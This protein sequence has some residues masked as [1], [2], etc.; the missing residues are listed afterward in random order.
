MSA[1]KKYVPAVPFSIKQ[2]P[3]LSEQWIKELIISNPSILGLEGELQ[4]SAVEKVQAS[5]GRLDLQLGDIDSDRRYEVEIQLGAT[6]ESHIIRTIEYWDN[7]RKRDPHF[8]HVAVII[9][10]EI[11]SRFFNVISLFHGHIP[12]IAIKMSAFSVGGHVTVSFT[13]VLDE[14]KTNRV[15][16]NQDQSEVTRATWET[17]VSKDA[18]AVVDSLAAKVRA[19]VGDFSLKYNRHYI[20]CVVDGAPANFI[21]FRPQRSGYRIDLGFKLSAQQVRALEDAG[22][23]VLPYTHHWK[24]HPIKLTKAQALNPPAEVLDVI[25]E[26]FRDYFG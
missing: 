17:N 12:L 10:E 22:I 6:D 24:V 14:T 11:T 7:E 21:L 9:A 5:R 3:T 15:R 8:D 26:S 18:L 1:A 4:I 16:T 25:N 19:T 13:K 23:E 2:E 20:G